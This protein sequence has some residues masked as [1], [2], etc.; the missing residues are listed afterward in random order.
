M[1]DGSRTV[2]P[3]KVAIACQGGGT[4]AAFAY[5]VLVE[6][7]DQ[8]ASAE[9]PQVEI[10]ALTG[11]SAGALNALMVWYGL[12][13]KRGA[14]PSVSYKAAR[15]QLVHF[16]ETF[17]ATEIAEI[18]H[19]TLT[20]SLLAQHEREAPI[21]GMTLPS[22]TLNPHGLFDDL[23]I[24]QYR[25]F[26]ARAAYFDFTELLAECCPAFDAIDWEKTTTRLLVGASEIQNGVETVF[27]SACNAGSALAAATRE[28]TTAASPWRAR[29]PL[30]LAGVAASGTLPWVK[31][32]EEIDGKHYWD[33]LYSQNPPIRELVAGVDLAHTPDEIWVVRI[34]PQQ[35]AH[36]PRTVVEIRDRENELMGN[37]SLNK[38]LD[39]IVTVNKWLERYAAHAESKAAHDFANKY[40][41]VTVRTLKMSRDTAASLRMVS[42]YDRS[43]RFIEEL[44]DEGAAVAKDW[45]A[46][47]PEVGTYPDDAAYVTS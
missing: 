36:L 7:L 43:R 34:N 32:A 25:Q 16:W 30:S 15:D 22:A 26:G 38:E 3:I 6:L 23:V 24:W 18:A 11:T 19:N 8:L 12:A 28:R 45:L 47:W 40:K 14:G 17:T 42:K 9:A 29:L 41:R 4:H 33:G 44:R 35:T 39:F 37:L 20:Q 1:M 5:G 13:P 27:D 2:A 46:R 21:F 31:V 10:V